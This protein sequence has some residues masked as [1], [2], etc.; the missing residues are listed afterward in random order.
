MLIDPCEAIFC[1]RFLIKIIQE[2]KIPSNKALIMIF[3]SI[4]AAVDYVQFSTDR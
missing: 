1:S 3:Q 2:N 4:V